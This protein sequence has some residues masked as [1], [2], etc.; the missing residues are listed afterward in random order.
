MSY[1]Q[2]KP[3]RSPTDMPYIEVE[4]EYQEEDEQSGHFREVWPNE[5]KGRFAV[6]SRVPYYYHPENNLV[7]RATVVLLEFK[8]FMPRDASAFPE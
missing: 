8:K 4:I 2:P 6:G 7:K 1:H 5:Y 3:E